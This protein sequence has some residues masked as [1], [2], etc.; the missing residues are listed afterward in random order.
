M[1]AEEYTK[2]LAAGGKPYFPPI[3]TS[4]QLLNG[5]LWLLSWKTADLSSAWATEH[6]EDALT[7]QARLLTSV[8]SAIP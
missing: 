6:L 7:H 4:I 3:T 5:G 1:T 2:W 8:S